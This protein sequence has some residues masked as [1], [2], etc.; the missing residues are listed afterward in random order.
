MGILTSQ[1]IAS[2]Y[3]RF[4]GIEVTY[5]KEITQ[6][7]GLQSKQIYL[8][9][10][11]DVWPCVI[12][13]SSFQGAKVVINIKSGLIPKL[14]QANNMVSLRFC[15]MDP[16]Q[17]GAQITF[18]VAARSMGYSP[19]GEA[20][21]AGLLTIQFT[22]RPPDDLIEIMGRLLDANVNSTRRKGE[23]IL[24]TPEILRK[25]KIRSS[26]CAVFIQGVP[27]R[28][29]LRDISFGGARLII[30]GVVKFLLEKEASLRIDF[31]DPRESF[32]LKGKF[33]QAEN[34]A[35]RKDMAIINLAFTEGQVSMGYKMR[36]N[37]YLATVR[38]WD[39][40]SS[41]KAAEGPA[42]SPEPAAGQPAMEN[43][44][45]AGGGA[46]VKNLGDD[47]AAPETAAEAP[48]P[49][50]SSAAAAPLKPAG[51][52]AAAPALKTAAG[53]KS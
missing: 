14:Q 44:P 19:Y 30:Q 41:A 23:R 50:E 12:Y 25:L 6:V 35:Y 16:F 34:V 24:I 15:F 29:I 5:S 2:L 22:Q 49:A 21:D 47:S 46:T 10:V 27:R 33:T 1:K 53:G 7:T 3:E 17:E 48:A 20:K 31:D 8:K 52:S 40:E 51:K 11:S 4:R 13:S 45:D 38:G 26:E 39:G 32:L 9:C 37:E 42:L 36:I 43:P 18:F 28:C